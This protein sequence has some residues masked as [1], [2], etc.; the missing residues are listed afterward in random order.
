[1]KDIDREALINERVREI[2]EAE[3]RPAGQELRHR[4]LA[5]RALSQ[6]LP[7]EQAQQPDY[8]GKGQPARTPERG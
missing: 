2:W 8:H 6:P 7:I 4:Q 5:E 3:G 1:M